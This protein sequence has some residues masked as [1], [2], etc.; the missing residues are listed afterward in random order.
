MDRRPPREI[1]VSEH[2]AGLVRS[3]SGYYY[4]N[5]FFYF[6]FCGIQ[7]TVGHQDVPHVSSHPTLPTSEV[8]RGFGASLLT[9]WATISCCPKPEKA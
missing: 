3:L 7:H 8:Q 9:R 2:V 1:R 5:L 4:N 6:K